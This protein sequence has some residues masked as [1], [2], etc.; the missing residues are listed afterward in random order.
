MND[1]KIAKEVVEDIKDALADKYKNKYLN[2]INS[3]ESR[4]MF[5]IEE[6]YDVLNDEMEAY[7]ESYAEG[8]KII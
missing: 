3:E 4:L 5:T 2:W 8:E 7:E 6:I 1:L